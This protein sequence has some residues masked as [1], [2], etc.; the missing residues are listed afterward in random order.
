MSSKRPEALYWCFTINNPGE[1]DGEYDIP[2]FWPD[3]R[4]CIWQAEV[5]A[6]GTEHLQG[7]VAFFS[8]KRLSAL[9][10]L[11]PEAHWEIRR[12]THQ[13]AKA[14]CMKKDNPVDGPWEIGSEEGIP[15]GPGARTDIDALKVDMDA[16]MSLPD[17]ALNHTAL[18]LRYDRGIRNYLALRSDFRKFQPGEKP[19][20][21]VLTGPSGCGKTRLARECFP[22]AYWVTKPTGNQQLWFDDYSGQ[23]VIVFDEFY[24]WVPYDFL[25]R[26]LDYGEMHL[27]FKGGNAKC[28]A[29]IFV[30]TSNMPYSD[31]YPKIED[32]TAFY[33]R[34]SEFGQ[35]YHWNLTKKEFE[36]IV[37]A[38]FNKMN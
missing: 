13:Q 7:Y 8:K 34:L 25:L 35:V 20:V 17:L 3:V 31:W 16:G 2:R 21:F 10:K 23:E 5:G 36:R 27:P 15:K 9:K 26:L 28:R 29:K 6:S 32:K 14:Y 37:V 33:R 22:G 12:G 1:I 38:Y 19:V 4:Y 18:F 11:S 24:S 30:F